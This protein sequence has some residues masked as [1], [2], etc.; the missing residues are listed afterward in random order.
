MWKLIKYELQARYYGILIFLV[1]ILGWDLSW[2]IY[3]YKNFRSESIETFSMDIIGICCV[4]IVLLFL[5]ILIVNINYFYRYFQTN[6]LSLLQTVPLKSWKILI[7][8]FITIILEFVGLYTI[9]ICITSIY[10]AI[11]KHLIMEF[12]PD[13]YF[14]RLYG[15]TNTFK[16]MFVIS[17][18]LFFFYTIN[19]LIR[20]IS[21][22]L[23]R[24][25]A[26]TTKSIFGI[27]FIIDVFHIIVFVSLFFLILNKTKNWDGVTINLFTY[28]G[29]F[30]I[31]IFLIVFL[32]SFLFIHWFYTRKTDF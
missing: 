18:F 17:L 15:V 10:Y 1:G 16:T 11:S 23:V 4:L 5:F 2:Y 9:Q 32:F 8:K 31:L 21:I 27:S 20:F 13:S 25:I 12:S 7:S 6:N 28:Q 29:F 24:H 19:I 14:T 3:F 30:Y 22:L 26:Q